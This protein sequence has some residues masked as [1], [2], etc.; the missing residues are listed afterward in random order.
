MVMLN[1]ETQYK[2]QAIFARVNYNWQQRYIVNLTARRD[3]S[4]RFGPGNQF[5]NFSAIGAAWLFSNENFLKNTS[6]FSFGKIRMS[7]GT[8]GN[9]Q[10]GDYQFLNTYTTS[11]V[12][13]NGTVG[14]Q[15]SRLFNPDFGWE[16]NKKLEFAI[17]VG[18][19]NDRIFTTASWYQNRSSNQLVGIPLPGTTGFSTLQA[20]LDATVE[21][22]G[23]EFTLRTINFNQTAFKWST[24]FNL[25]FAKN[26][27]LHFP[28]LESSSYNQQYRIGKPLNIALLYLYKGINP[29]SGVYEFEDVN[30]DGI[31]SFPEDKQSI[32]DLNPKYYGGI[33][34]QLSYKRWNFDF[35]FQFV[36]QKNRTFPMGPAGMMSNQQDR[37]ADS[38]T[39]PGDKAPYQI[40]TTGYNY[41]ALMA[42]Y[43]YSESNASITDASF[44][45][46]KNVSLSYE[47]PLNL[48]QTNCKIMLQGHNLLTF[49]KYKDGDPEFT[50]YG[51]LPPL[52]IITAGVQL[53]F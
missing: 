19:F 3:G 49:T 20:N 31:I 5:A 52:K 4:S 33:Q 27:L 25:S 26:K 36:K 30:Q 45:R 48:K 14:L 38:W 24:N 16:I 8:T 43:Y 29:Q 22:K 46:L 12:S 17:E 11:G 13:Y 39:Q 40:N 18:F 7:Y 34:N 21:N 32:A 2:Y 23:L 51:F 35:L 15:P 9:D 50:S 10:I 37:I 28:N 1:D 42:D 47:L 6:W 53:T 41:D 44:I